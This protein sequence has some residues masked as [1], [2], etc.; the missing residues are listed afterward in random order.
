GHVFRPRLED[1]KMWLLHIKFQSPRDRGMSSGTTQR[2]P[3][4]FQ[5]HSFNPLVIWACLQAITNP[6]LAYHVILGMFQSPRDRDMSSGLTVVVEPTTRL[7]GFNPLVIGAC[8]QAQ[9]TGWSTLG[10]LCCFNP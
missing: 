1:K 2:C 4:F 8:L 5:P 10:R 9:V 6:K 3:F 7:T